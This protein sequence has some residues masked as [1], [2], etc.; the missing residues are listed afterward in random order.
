MYNFVSKI[1]LDCKL[2]QPRRRA[3][4]HLSEQRATDISVDGRR[5]EELG[6]VERVE[7]L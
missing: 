7:G 6:V 1:K 2:H 4:H 3:V 5:S